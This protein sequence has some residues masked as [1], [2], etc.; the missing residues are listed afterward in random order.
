MLGMRRVEIAFALVIVLWGS[1]M[2]RESTHLAVG[3]GPGGPGSGFFPFWLSVG[4]IVAALA[5][6]AQAVRGDGDTQERRRFIPTGAFP[7]L[8]RAMLPVAGAV[9]AM[10]LVG[11]YLAA[12]LY[13]AYSTRWIGRLR[14]ALVLA[15][16]LLFPLAVRLVIERW[17]LVPLPKGYF[18]IPLP[19]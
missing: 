4:L 5:V 2:L 13:L 19:F 10:E 12:A 1:L 3:W 18:A 17:F 14:W 8:L 15:V 6:L 11:F 16:S 7:L 9:L